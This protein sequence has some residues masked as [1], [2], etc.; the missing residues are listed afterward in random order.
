MKV[1]CLEGLNKR[2]NEVAL[3]HTSELSGI[4]E[5]Q[6]IVHFGVTGRGM[7]LE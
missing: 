2:L 3:T 5:V 6:H 4:S 7:K 1:D